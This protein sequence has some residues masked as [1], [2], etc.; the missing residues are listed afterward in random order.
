M[1]KNRKVLCVGIVLLMLVSLSAC[2]RKRDVVYVDGAIDS[3]TDSDVKENTGGF[4]LSDTLGVDEDKWVEEIGDIK[5]SADI[6]VPDTNVMC[7]QEFEEYYYTNADKK[8]FMESVF[9]KDSQVLDV[10]SRDFPCRESVEEVIREYKESIQIYQ[11]VIESDP[12]DK[13][14][15]PYLERDSKIVEELEQ[16]LGSLPARADVSTDVGNYEADIYL[17]EMDGVEYSVKFFSDQEKKI[18]KIIMIP[19]DYSSFNHTGIDEPPEESGALKNSE[20]LNKTEYTREEM[21]AIAYDFL[22]KLGISGMKLTDYA[23]LTWPRSGEL[24]ESDETGIISAGASEYNGYSFLFTREISGID[25]GCRF[26]YDVNDEGFSEG[27]Y[28]Q[29]R[30]IVSVSDGGIVGFSYDGIL[31]PVGEPVEAKLLSYKDIKDICKKNKE[32]FINYGASR[33]ELT[34]ER[35][36]SE[37]SPGRYCYVPTW[38]VSKYYYGNEELIDFT[39][40]SSM[41]SINAIDGSVVLP[42]MRQLD[43]TWNDYTDEYSKRRIYN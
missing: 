31:K 5:F 34:Y 43:G 1:I 41:L 17:A 12:D 25:I 11:S 23:L 29:E 42:T 18:S 39:E 37:T 9:D 3:A 24:I 15:R 4:T 13:T 19:T 6:I 10:M 28:A 7:T 33:C 2:G 40:I 16:K 21:E 27:I 22:N 20:D 8:K 14:L 36:A 32:L 38:E 26:I 35:V 30:I